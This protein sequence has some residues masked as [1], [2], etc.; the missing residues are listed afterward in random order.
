MTEVFEVRLSPQQRRLWLL[1]EIHGPWNVEIEAELAG[2]LDREALDAAIRAAVERHDIL[3]TTFQSIPGMKMP[4]QVIGEEGSLRVE[5]LPVGPDRHR[6]T[7]GLPALCGDLGTLRLLLGEIAGGPVS[8]VMQYWH[9]SEWLNE[10]LEDES[11]A[12]ER[13]YWQRR[14]LGAPA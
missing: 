2:P 4:V 10:L 12:G 8:E 13:D 7:L 1:Q 5:V 3:R 11:Y 9:Y 14:L 6:L